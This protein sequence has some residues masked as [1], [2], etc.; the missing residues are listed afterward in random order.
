MISNFLILRSTGDSE[1]WPRRHWHHR[2]DR[3]EKAQDWQMLCSLFLLDK[4]VTNSLDCA[5]LTSARTEQGLEGMQRGLT[6]IWAHRQAHSFTNRGRKTPNSEIGVGG[7][8]KLETGSEM[9]GQAI[10]PTGRELII[11]RESQCELRA[12]H[13][14]YLLLFAVLFQETISF[15]WRLL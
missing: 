5:F 14:T 8:N 12:L 6:Y 15:I 13:W 4:A 11:P 7:Q 1:W 2:G 3:A 9:T 10:Q